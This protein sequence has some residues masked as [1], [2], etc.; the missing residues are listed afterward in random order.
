MPPTTGRVKRPGP[1]AS[2][3]RSIIDNHTTAFF[4]TLNKNAQVPTAAMAAAVA[5]DPCAPIQARVAAA[6]HLHRR[7][8]RLAR[9]LPDDRA[10]Q[11]AYA[12]RRGMLPAG[13]GHA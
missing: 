2:G 8:H 10:V 3:P 1:P 13:G 6:C 9:W 4:F 5:A 12:R 11:Q 7:R